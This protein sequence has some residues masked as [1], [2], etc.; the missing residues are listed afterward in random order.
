MEV[1]KIIVEPPGKKAK[2]VVEEDAKYIA[3]STKTSPVVA[4]RAKNAIVEDVDGNIYIDFSSGIG[5]LNIG[6]CHPAVVEAVKSQA[7][8]L[9]HFAGTDFYYEIQV[10]LAKKLCS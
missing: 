3:T 4:A 10:E 5:V 7:G 2:K 1:P 9:F 8:K 6:H